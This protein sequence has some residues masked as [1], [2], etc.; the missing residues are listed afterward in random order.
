MRTPDIDEGQPVRAASTNA[1]NNV[2]QSVPQAVAQLKSITSASDAVCRAALRI[3][4]NDI[5]S[6]VDLVLSGDSRLQEDQQEN[7]IDTAKDTDASATDANHEE[8]QPSETVEESETSPFASDIS[9]VAKID[10]VESASATG[11]GPYSETVLGPEP[12]L[13]PELEPNDQPDDESEPEGEPDDELEDDELEDAESSS[14]FSASSSAFFASPSAFIA[15]SS[16][17]FASSSAFFASS[18][19]PVAASVNLMRCFFPEHT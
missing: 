3:S 7:A 17:F 15:S 13:E 11:A 2:L 8:P 10:T 14:D 1:T 9:P 5:S 16:A 19:A 12:E 4:D 6:A 18:S